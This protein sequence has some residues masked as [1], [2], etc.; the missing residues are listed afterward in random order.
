MSNAFCTRCGAPLAPGSAFCASCGA[1]VETAP[2]AQPA[3]SA[4]PQ[5]QPMYNAAPQPQYAYPQPRGRIS[6][7]AVIGI[8]A[9]AAA[10]VAGAILLIVLLGGG[11]D[12]SIKAADIC[13]DW[14]GSI[15]IENVNTNID[16]LDNYADPDVI[17]K[18]AGTTQD[19]MLYIESSEN[20]NISVSGN[21]AYN[22]VAAYENGR[23][24]I[25]Q[26]H[27]GGVVKLN[28]EGSVNRKD[29]SYVIKGT[30]NMSYDS[31]VFASG[32]WT[33]EKDD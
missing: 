23:L 1:R 13:G 7:G 11:G 9:G 16:G 4:A 31:K 28:M 12:P 26:E 10:V 30:W 17:E 14:S 22:P 27:E 20:G 3:Y 2:Q 32:T 25:E 24:T 6:T 21:I 15:S 19:M 29:D 8:I 33:V 18:D 5:P